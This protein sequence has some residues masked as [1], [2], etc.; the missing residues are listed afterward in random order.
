VWGS[1]ANYEAA[2]RIQR[3]QEAAALMPILNDH[4]HHHHQ[5]QQQQF[6][7]GDLPQ[8]SSASVSDNGEQVV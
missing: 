2:Q 3:E 1:T 4:H 5:Q 6:W 8:P 7:R